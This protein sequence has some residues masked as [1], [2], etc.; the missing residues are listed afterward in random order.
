MQL[1]TID[2]IRRYPVSSLSGERLPEAKVAAEGLEGDR[3]WGLFDAEN[4]SVAAPESE[5]RWR[6]VPGLSA[7][8]GE[9][10]PEI[11]QNGIAW[12]PL[13]AAAADR[14]ASDHL[15][16][17]TRFLPFA[18]EATPRYDRAPLHIL[19]TASLQALR[20]RL[21]SAIIEIPRFRPNLLIGTG[22]AIDGFAEQ[23]LVGKRLSIGD[24]VV[25]ISEPCRRCAFTALGQP[26]L[27]FDKDVLHAIS[28]AG[29]GFGVLARVI[30]AGR[31]TI[32]DAAVVM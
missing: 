21:P 20:A 18:A 15:G 31:V 28:R 1:G 17:R 25:E 10:G 23:S 2:E 11:S 22:A 8:F 5:K 29:G 24:A 3:L 32:G 14:L 6:P 12:L 9:E 13:P 16:F 30:Q 4:L 19:T 7:R 27:P 26:G